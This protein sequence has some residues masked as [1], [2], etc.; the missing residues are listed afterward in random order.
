[1]GLVLHKGQAENIK[2]DGAALCEIYINGEGRR[3]FAL[4]GRKKRKTSTNQDTR[5][6]LFTKY[7]EWI[8]DPEPNTKKVKSYRSSTVMCKGRKPSL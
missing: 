2:W 7:K 5:R 4:H 8:P 3:Q 6:F 1:M